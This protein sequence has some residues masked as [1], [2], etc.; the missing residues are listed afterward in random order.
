MHRDQPTPGEWQR[1]PGPF[2]K[3]FRMVGN[4]KEY[5][6]TVM[7]STRGTIPQSQIGESD[8]QQREPRK[9]VPP[10]PPVWCPIMSGGTSCKGEKCALYAGG[11]CALANHRGDPPA[12]TKGR[13][14]PFNPYQCRDDCGLYRN[15]CLLTARKERI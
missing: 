7:T 12:D 9:F 4:V 3:R 1:E 14:C 13:K 2:G 6:M 8:G 15:G 11:V 5:E 10:P